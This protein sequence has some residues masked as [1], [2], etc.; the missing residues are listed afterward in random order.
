MELDPRLT[1]SQL[2]LPLRTVTEESALG[3]SQD[4]HRPLDPRTGSADAPQGARQTCCHVRPTIL[5]ILATVCC[6]VFVLIC[7]G[8]YQKTAWSVSLSC[9][10]LVTGTSKFADQLCQYNRDPLIRRSFDSFFFGMPLALFCFYGFFITHDT[11]AC[12][13]FMDVPNRTGELCIMAGLLLCGWITIL[14]MALAAFNID[15]NADSE[16]NDRAEQGSWYGVV[17]VVFRMSELTYRI[18]MVVIL[19]DCIRIA[20]PPTILTQFGRTSVILVAPYILLIVL[21]GLILYF[22]NPR[23]PDRARDDIKAVFVVAVTTLGINSVH[24]LDRPCCREAAVR[25]RRRLLHLRMAEF[26]VCAVA[27]LMSW[28]SPFPESQCRGPFTDKTFPR[29]GPWLLSQRLAT[30]LHLLLPAAL[31][32]ALLLYHPSISRS[33]RQTP[34]D[35]GGVGIAGGSAGNPEI[36]AADGQMTRPESVGM[37]QTLVHLGGMGWFAAFVGARQLDNVDHFRHE[38][39]LG[40]GQYGVVVLTKR[41]YAAADAPSSLDQ[42]RHGQRLFA[43]KL[44]NTSMRRGVMLKFRMRTPLEL[45]RREKDVYRRIWQ[46]IGALDADEPSLARAGHPFIVR[47]HYFFSCPEDTTFD[48]VEERGDGTTQVT[49]ITHNGNAVFHEG[50]IMEYCEG[51]SLESFAQ[52]RL[53]AA[54]SPADIAEFDVVRRFI[55]EVLLALDFL[56]RVKRV[57]YRDLNL[58]N[59][60]VVR[61]SQHEHVKLGDFG[62]SKALDDGNQIVSAAG[63]PYWWA[64]EMRRQLDAQQ[65][66]DTTLQGHLSLDVFSFGTLVFALAH[67]CPYLP[68]LPP[69]RDH[70]MCQAGQARS[71]ATEVSWTCG[72]RGCASLEALEW[73]F[74]S[75]FGNACLRDL[76]RTCVAFDSGRRPPTQDLRRS[77]LFHTD[78]DDER[79]GVDGKSPKID[80]ARLLAANF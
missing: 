39:L 40:A 1:R 38:R 25:A 45:A 78:F 58:S 50:L 77:P 80:F 28:A 76:V 61:R 10:L 47:L 41:D 16:V 65:P 57:V 79:P 4:S 60:F 73:R 59:V 26:T 64:P 6:Y 29:F 74:P 53:T 71:F 22:A 31:H 42:Q 46:E 75:R 13:W 70:P 19:C 51:G 14:S 32:H 7:F 36:F 55:A 49:H 11:N 37:C 30:V 56:H 24:F 27:M 3:S 5:L 23:G 33:L 18:H 44:V 12:A 34:L 15:C 66:L 69:G 67:G 17:H 9:I 63:T 54:G 21:N 68:E 48:I 2:D 43:M 8:M 20:D 72:C 62:F 35:A 52:E